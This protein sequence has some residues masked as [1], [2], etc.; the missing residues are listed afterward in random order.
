[1]SRTLENYL[2]GYN[3]KFTK[4]GNNISAYNN[5]TLYNSTDE[6]ELPESLY[7]HYLDIEYQTHIQHLPNE[8]YIRGSFDMS[9]TNID[10]I[11]FGTFINKEIYTEYT[12]L[13]YL[14]TLT[15]NGYFTTDGILS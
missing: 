3:K 8:L 9:S 12:E 11:P 15:I 1:M 4:F 2:I 6:I 10:F 13:S 14:D 7:A 5:I